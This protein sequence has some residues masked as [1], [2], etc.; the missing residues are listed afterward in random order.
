MICDMLEYGAALEAL[1]DTQYGNKVKDDRPFLL[2]NLQC[3]NPDEMG[4]FGPDCQHGQ[5]NNT[6]CKPGHEAVVKCAKP[7]MLEKSII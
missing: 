3:P 2:G 1:S 5:W 6:D 4:P 7:G